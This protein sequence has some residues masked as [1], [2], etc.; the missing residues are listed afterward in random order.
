MVLLTCENIAK[1]YTEKPLLTDINMS[2]HD[3]DKIGF[4]GV[5]GTGKSTLLRLIAGTMEPEGGRIIRSGALKAGYLAQDTPYLEE[6]TVLEHVIKTAAGNDPSIEEYRCKA[7]LGKLGIE[8][9]SLPMRTLSGGQRKRAALTAVLVQDTNLLIL[10][11]PTNHMDSEM[12]LW[13]EHYLQKYKGAIFMIT[14]DRYF[15]DRVTNRI[16]ELEK[17][18]LVSYEANYDGYL[19]A[20]AAREEMELATERKRL[21]LYRKELAWIRRGAQARSTKAKGRIQRFEALEDSKLVRES[22][23]LEMTTISS[24][25]GKKIIEL[26]NISKGY[27]EKTL[28][29]SFSYTLLRNDRIGII[30]PNGCGKS[31][32]LKIITGM[33]EPDSGQIEK[34]ETIKIGYF[35]QENE[36][37]DFSQRIIKY[38]E[39][40]ARQI[41]T[42]EGIVSASQML[43]RFLF[44]PHMH[45]VEIGRLS[46]GEKRRLYLLS[47]LMQAPNVLIFDEPTNDL[48]IETLTVLEDYLDDF[49]GAVILVSHD[50]YFLDR[51]AE[52]MFVFEGA[53]KIAHYPGGYSDWYENH[54]NRKPDRP[55]S[56]PAGR[57]DATDGE[58]EAAKEGHNRK[59][60]PKKLK[61]TY[62]E[63]REYETIEDDIAGLESKIRAVEEEMMKNATNSGRLT[64]LSGEKDTLEEEL[65]EKME[66]WEYLMNL[67]ERIEAGEMV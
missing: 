33:L 53:G 9:S 2:I 24:R 51:L 14:H 4:V 66:R 39:S 1:S 50:R 17:G 34:G 28:I 23:S 48:D 64:E 35:S 27:E 29:D 62:K 36:A 67:A 31:T 45:S 46:G 44:P 58:T 60:R 61:F 43:E 3:T 22:S 56:K 18:K 20:K 63:A 15:L 12:I 37:L 19:E 8:D 52:R 41:R 21:S 6:E 54:R 38:I 55:E 40:I 5:N 42:K 26:D 65:M 16:V 11:E 49:P 10:D 30:G 25:L 7:M 32:L 59:S 57:K 13:L 47:I